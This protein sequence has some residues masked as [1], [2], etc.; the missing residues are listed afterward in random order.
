MDCKIFNQPLNS[1]DVSNVKNMDN[2]FN[3]WKLFNQP[4]D[5]WTV[6]KSFNIRCMFGVIKNVNMPLNKLNIVN[7][8][9]FFFTKLIILMNYYIKFN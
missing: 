2:M 7:I 3:G 8:L 5:S 9:D 1:W 4:L 6:S